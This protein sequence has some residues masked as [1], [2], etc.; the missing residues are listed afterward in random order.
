L[1]IKIGTLEAGKTR[2]H[3]CGP[4]TQR[5]YPQ[6]EKVFFVMKEGAIFRNDNAGRSALIT[7]EEILKRNF[8]NLSQPPRQ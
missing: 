2:G 1:P 3:R 6:V 4:G 8:P 7:G 5:K